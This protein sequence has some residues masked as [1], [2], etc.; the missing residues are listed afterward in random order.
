MRPRLSLL[1]LTVAILLVSASC[2]GGGTKNSPPTV[3]VNAPSGPPAITRFEMNPAVIGLGGHSTLRWDT[4]N[5]TSVTITPSVLR[6][7][8]VSLGPSDPG[9]VVIP[10]PIRQTITYVLTATGPGGPPATRS[11]T[12]TVPA[13]A[14][15]RWHADGNCDYDGHG[16]RQPAEQH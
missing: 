15:H 9:R 16:W 11:V 5:A 10:L 1:F 14:S 7:D 12:L 3:T 13:V 4:A 8:E 6:Q 2:G